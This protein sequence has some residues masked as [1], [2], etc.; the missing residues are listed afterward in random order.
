MRLGVLEEAMIFGANI[1][2]NKQG[3][4]LLQPEQQERVK[5]K[6]EKTHIQG[7]MINFSPNCSADVVFQREKRAENVFCLYSSHL[8]PRHLVSCLEH[9]V[10]VPLT[11]CY[12]LQQHEKFSNTRHMHC[13]SLIA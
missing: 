7:Q 13:L 6:L 2:K 3:V 12:H 5:I 9:A 11:G 1:L 10:L 8:F 4:K